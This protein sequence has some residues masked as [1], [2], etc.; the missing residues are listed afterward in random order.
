MKKKEK[1][2]GTHSLKTK[3]FFLCLYVFMDFYSLNFLYMIDF[4]ISISYH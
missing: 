3:S 4:R 1:E 2:P